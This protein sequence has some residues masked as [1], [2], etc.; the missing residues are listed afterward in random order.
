[1]RG[2][3]L[4][5]ERAKGERTCSRCGE[6]KKFIFKQYCGRSRV[7]MD[8]N[9]K[10]WTGSICSDCHRKKYGAG[11]GYGTKRNKIRKL[12]QSEAITDADLELL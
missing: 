2:K 3:P 12:K 9:G 1:M 5:E 11:T 8:E 6:T 4:T 10:N 7:F